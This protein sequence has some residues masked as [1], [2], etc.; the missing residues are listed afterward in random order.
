[1]GTDLRIVEF[2][3][4]LELVDVHEAGERDSVPLEDWVPLHAP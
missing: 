3:V 2:E 4:A 1:M